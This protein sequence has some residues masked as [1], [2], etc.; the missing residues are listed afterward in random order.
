MI[1]RFSSEF[2]NFHG[3][4]STADITLYYTTLSPPSRTVLLV[5]KAIGIELS[6]KVLD[7]QKGEHL[8]PELLKVLA[9]MSKVGLVLFCV[10]FE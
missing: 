1:R 9:N 3:I 7:M 4:N 8:T 10:Y 6:L 2:V 5:A